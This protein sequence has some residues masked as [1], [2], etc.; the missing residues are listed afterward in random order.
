MQGNREETPADM[1]TARQ[2]AQELFDAGEKQWGTD[3]SKFKQILCHRSFPQLRATFDEYLKVRIQVLI[4]PH[5]V[6]MSPN[7]CF[8]VPLHYYTIHYLIPI[9][10]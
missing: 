8:T 7:I 10:R 3:E 5:Q 1:E 4:E 6:R 9:Y 2:E